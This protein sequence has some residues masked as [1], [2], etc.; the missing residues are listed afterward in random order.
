MADIKTRDTVKGTIKTLDKTTVAGQKMKEAYIATKEKAERSVNANENTAE[1]YAADKVQSGID[2]ISHDVVYAFDKTGRK[3]VRETKRNIQSAKD[4]FQRFKQQRAEQSLR[5]QTAQNTNFAI[6]TVDTAEKTIKQSATSSGKK[7]IKFSGKEAA[8]TTQ[9]SVKTAEQTAKAAIKTS[10]QTAKAAQ[11]TAQA[12]VKASQ[13]AAQAAKATAKAT[14]TAVKAAAKATIAAVKAII[15]AAKV[16]VAAIAARRLG[17]RCCD[18]SIMS[19]RVNCRF[20]LWHF[21]FRGRFRYRNVNADCC[22]RNQS[23]IR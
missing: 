1:E 6:K 17:C 12:T 23:R 22:A 4:G 5:K 15:A 9:K 19:C 10:Q 2:E 11:K 16:F 20:S 18:Y 7:T 3:G 8:K 14:A 13:K 21:L